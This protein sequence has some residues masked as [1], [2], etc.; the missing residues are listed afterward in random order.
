MCA[1]CK[2]EREER[3]EER[4]RDEE[5]E[6]REREKEG[7]ETERLRCGE[8]CEPLPLGWLSPLSYFPPF[9]YL[10]TAC[11]GAVGFGFI[12]FTL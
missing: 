8:K 11:F 7:E 6:E 10:I 3:E 5:E 4:E 2:R 1:L 12:F 9:L